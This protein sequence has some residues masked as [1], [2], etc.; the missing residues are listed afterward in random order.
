[1]EPDARSSL[2][3]KGAS[4]LPRRDLREVGLELGDELGLVLAGVGAGEEPVARLVVES[5]PRLVLVA[6]IDGSEQGLLL[7]GKRHCA[8]DNRDPTSPL[9]TLSP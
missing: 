2:P 4:L 1:M 3:A 9:T 5:L 8:T 7:V 6:R